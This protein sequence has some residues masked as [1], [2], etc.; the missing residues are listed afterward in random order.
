MNKWQR[1]T[2]YYA[3]LLTGLMLGYAAVYNWGMVT[4]E[5]AD[6]VSGTFLHALQVVVETFTTTGFGSD[7]PWETR[8]MNVL[9]ILMDT[10]GTLMIFLALPVL[11]FPALEDILS[12]S[13]PRSVGDQSDHVVVATYSARAE[14]LI[15]ELGARDVDYVLVEPDRDRAIDLYE[16][17]YDVIEADPETTDGLRHANLSDARAVVADVTD[18]VDT[19]IV[20]TAREISEEI[21]VV[22][23]VEEPDRTDYHRLA[24]ADEVLSPRPLLGQRLGD[25]ASTGVATKLGDRFELGEDFELAE[26]LVHRDSPLVGATLADSDIRERTGVNVIGAWSRGEF[27]SPVG[28]DLEIES[29]MALVVTGRRDQLERLEALEASTVRERA[30]GDVLVIGYGEVGKAVTRELDTVGQP[31]TVLDVA[32]KPGVDVVGTADD[33]DALASAGL[34]DAQSVI[35]AIPDDTAAEFATL[36][37]RDARPDIDIA[38]RTEGADSVQKMYRA[39]ANYV[40]SLA[41]VAGRMAAAAVLDDADVVPT[42]TQ[43]EILE[44]TAPDLAGRTLGA[45]DVGDRTGAIVVA[46]ERD[47]EVYTDLGPEFRIEAGDELVVAGTERDTSAFLEAFT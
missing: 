33:T 16:S 34:A 8:F 18:R 43:V 17:G 13:V 5:G 45:A 19:S 37:I 31:F 22:S 3:V 2:V 38:A 46:V 6:G 10:T 35:L 30:A 24:G 47:G 27:R 29:G 42:T 32:D 4:L 11:L 1:R 23:V 15:E 21:Q 20:L 12:T 9:V 44:T 28:P 36:V 25:V 26:L 14:A 39:G 7:A 40:L 41:Q